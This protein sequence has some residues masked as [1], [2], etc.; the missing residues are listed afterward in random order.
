MIRARTL[1]LLS[2][3]LLLP[4]ALPATDAPP[5]TKEAAGLV[6]TVP[7]GWS[8]VTPSSRMRLA[9]I[10][11]PGEAGVATMTVFHFGPGGGGGVEDNLRRW[12]GQVGPAASPP[13]R[14]VLTAGDLEVHV[15]E[16][17]GTMAPVRTDSQEP[18][19]DQGLIGAVVEGA[20]GPWF[21][22]LLGP[23]ATVKAARPA[24]RGML[25]ALHR[26]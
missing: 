21:L 13:T 8:A 2:V 5:V 24:M 16:A 26:R 7:A 3:A 4:A 9:E 17:Q 23:A 15:V 19:P 10:Q 22:K 1:V 11:V 25:L 14:E 20:G 12:V 18:V 6:L